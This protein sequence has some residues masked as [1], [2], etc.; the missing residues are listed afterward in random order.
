[1]VKI[2]LDSNIL[3]SYL[4][5][6][7]SDQYQGVKE[8]IDEIRIGK[9]IPYVSGIIFLEIYFVLVS[10]Y[11]FNKTEV[12]DTINKLLKMRNL[13]II[14][15]TDTEEALKCCQKYKIKL[16]DCFIATQIPDN[17]KLCTFDRDFRKFPFLEIVTPNEIIG[18][19]DK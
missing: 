17:V 3:V 18:T 6:R 5:I 2:F 12:L 9:I 19:L 16:S 15:K 13:V 11:K 10:V 7:D 8:L 14:E 4:T 1:M